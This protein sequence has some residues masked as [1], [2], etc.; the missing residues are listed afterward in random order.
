ME[1]RH[2]ISHLKMRD[3]KVI[4]LIITSLLQCCL[5]STSKNTN[6][7]LST[8][9]GF[10]VICFLEEHMED[11]RHIIE[12]EI[13]S[14]RP[15][16]PT[17]INSEL[18]LVVRQILLECPDIFWLTPMING[19]IVRFV[20]TFSHKRAIEAREQIDEIINNE[21]R[22]NHIRT[23]SPLEQVMYVYKW[24]ALYCDYNIYSAYNQTIYSVFVYRYSVCSGYA[25]AAQYLLQLLGFES[26]LVYGKL[27]NSDKGSRHCWLIVSVEGK[28]Y[29]LDPTFA[30]PSLQDTLKRAGVKP[31]VGSDGLCYNYFLVDTD[32]VKQSKEDSGDGNLIEDEC[33]L[34]LCNSN[35]DHSQLQY[36]QVSHVRRPILLIAKGTTADIFTWSDTTPGKRVA[37]FFRDDRN[38]NLLRHEYEIAQYLSDSQ[39]ILSVYS[40]EYPQKCLIIEQATPVSDLLCC[41]NYELSETDFCQ[42]LLD[43]I[44]GLQ[45]CISNR[46]FYRDIHINNV[47]RGSDGKYKLGDL[48]SCAWMDRREPDNE[49]CGIGSPWFMAPETYRDGT[50]NESS[51]IYGVGM[52]AYYLLNDLVPPFWHESGDKSLSQRM[53]A[54]DVVPV[55]IRLRNKEDMFQ[56][57]MLAFLKGTLDPMENMRPRSLSEMRHE[58]VF[59][60]SIGVDSTVLVKGGRMD[61]IHENKFIEEC[62]RTSPINP[63][64]QPVL[65]RNSYNKQKKE[66]Q[67]RLIERIGIFNNLL[68]A[69]GLQD[70]I[71][72]EDVIKNGFSTSLLRLSHSSFMSFTP[73]LN[74]LDDVKINEMS[75]LVSEIKYL[76]QELDELQGGDDGSNTL[77][78]E[79]IDEFATTA[80]CPRR[81]INCESDPV[82]SPR[83]KDNDCTNETVCLECIPQELI[84]ELESTTDQLKEFTNFGVRQTYAPKISSSS[85]ISRIFNRRRHQYVYSSVFAPSEIKTRT[86]MM[87]QVYLHLE[88]ETEKVKKLAVESDKN[89]ERR[90]YVPLKTKLKR[91]DEVGIEF[92]INGDRLLFNEKK[93]ILWQGS[94]CKCAFDFLVPENIETRELSCSVNL[95]V[96]NAI[97]GEMLFHTEIVDTP[98]NLNANVTS[99]SVNKL[100]ISYSHNDLKSAEK[101][102]KIHEALGIEVFF[103]K[104]RLKSG[105]IYSEEIFNFIKS[106]D[107]FVLCW[108]ENAAKSEYVE[109]E[110]KA[111]LERA[112]PNCK[113][114]EEALRIKPYCIEPYATPPSDMIEYYHFE[115]L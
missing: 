102:A 32:I 46:I 47:F 69:Y 99:R 88:E 10:G 23:L 100:F 105:Y 22:I 90:D 38:D 74:S 78:K 37:K 7:V 89:A 113:P 48:G 19:S 77:V 52:I 16:N 50:F 103:D 59:L 9:F 82:Q 79:R 83:I 81:H 21:F 87:V 57:A 61:K 66:I 13:R 33:N 53:A 54:I 31:V 92:S 49:L 111:A 67:D 75:L 71:L 27:K 28:W 76:S 42:F 70:Y 73:S 62:I 115:Q 12:Q 4:R 98:L 114:K 11:L 97:V 68:R 5:V 2:E 43:I 30:V 65:N 14:F 26:R 95:Y 17:A 110:R 106:A 80:S 91:G 107:T 55:P 58:I 64:T 112:Y 85:L 3:F 1:Q 39:H 104:H 6:F 44:D 60:S 40:I 15:I 29:H 41:P 25:K 101:I 56:R 94:F 51:A 108:S 96:N 18:Y 8:D 35:V 109:K 84:D 20:Y 36:I 72:P 45:E 34:P 86:R 24:L 63:D 93:N